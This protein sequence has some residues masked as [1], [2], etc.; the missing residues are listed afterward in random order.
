[1]NASDR[2]IDSLGCYD[3]AI[4]SLREQ[5]I[6]S[7]EYE[8]RDDQERRQALQGPCPPPDLDTVQA[9]RTEGA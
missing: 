6:R 7:G 4:A 1:M 2:A 3:L 9:K 5:R 8:P